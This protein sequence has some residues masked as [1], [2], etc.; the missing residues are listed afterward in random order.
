MPLLSCVIITFNEE[1]N[2]ERCI[3]SAWKVADEVI[4]VDSFSNDKTIEIAKELGATIYLEKFRGYIGQK[5]FAISLATHNYILS[6][7]ADEALD[8]TLTASILEVKKTLQ[9]RAYSMN[10]CTNFCG[11]FIRHGLWYPD[12]KIRLFDK[13]IAKWGGLNPHEKIQF[14]GHFPVKYL[15][16]EILH[17]SFNSI[18]DLVWQNNRLSTI[19]AASL[20]VNNKRS[21]WYKI[22]I[23][24]AWAFLNGYFFRLGFLDGASGFSIAIHTAHQVFM[25]YSKLY[26]MQTE[27]KKNYSS[28]LVK[29]ISA[30]KKN[31]PEKSI[32]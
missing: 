11:R 10:R 30:E 27:N 28:T 3:R 23:H 25:K 5:N 15:S 31:F 7:D 21:S 20:Y 32:N 4:V 26:R 16:G 9:Y 29:P 1:Q 13:T 8:N 19:A 24:P 17:Y 12:K 2:I 14:N 6:L 18:D 22:L